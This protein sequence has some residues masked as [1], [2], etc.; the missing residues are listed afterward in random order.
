MNI[1]F[2]LLIWSYQ[3]KDFLKRKVLIKGIKKNDLVL[4]VGSGDK[5]FWRADVIVDKY[6]EDDQQRHSGSVIFDNKK[7]FIKGDVENLPFKNKTFDFV[8]CSHLLEHVENPGKAIAELVRVARR[9][10]IEV[11]NAVLELIHPF[12]S[13]LWYCLFLDNTLIFRQKE[14]RNDFLIKSINLFGKESVN[15]GLFE[16]SLNRKINKIF[17]RIYWKDNLKNKTV[18]TEDKKNIYKYVENQKGTEKNRDLKT[19]F[20]FYKIFYYTIAF[21]FYKKKNIKLEELIKS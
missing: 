17:I 12:P 16:Y 1:F 9:G 6:F 2:K 4:D 21:L 13:H 11:P 15:D 14:K 5:P 7:I 10:Y 3:F 18:F 19:T 8:F 20:F